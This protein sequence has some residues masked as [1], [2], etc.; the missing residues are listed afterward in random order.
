LREELWV[1]TWESTMRDT[2]KTRDIGQASVDHPVGIGG[3]ATRKSRGLKTSGAWDGSQGILDI[4]PKGRTVQQGGSVDII[5]GHAFAHG[6]S[7]ILQLLWCLLR[8][9]IISNRSSSIVA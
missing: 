2:G 8:E 3:R 6:K 1:D 5:V 7:H 9:V 4:T